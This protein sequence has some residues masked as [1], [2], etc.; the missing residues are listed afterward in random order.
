MML[1]ITWQWVTEVTT[2]LCLF[3]AACI[4]LAATVGGSGAP[5][6]AERTVAERKS[7]AAQRERQD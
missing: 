7:M 2:V 6:A 1:A 4:A 3:G 5:R